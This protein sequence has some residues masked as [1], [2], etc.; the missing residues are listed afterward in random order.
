MKLINA[1]MV[2]LSTI[3]CI[4]CNNSSELRK[5]NKNGFTLEGQISKDSILN[6][7]ILFYDSNNVMVAKISYVNSIKEGPSI[8]YY[9]NGK[10]KDDIE[11]RQG[12]EN[13]YHTV[14]DSAGNIAYRDY[15]F[16][17]VQ[18]G[19]LYFYQNNKCKE[20]YFTS[21]ENETL[22][23]LN[24]DSLSQTNQN[25]DDYFHMRVTNALQDDK[26]KLYLFL[27][28]LNPPSKS[29]NYNICIEDSLDNI[30]NIRKMPSDKIFFQTY[31]DTLSNGNH[32][33]ISLNVYDSATRANHTYIKRIIL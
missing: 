4:G 33:C 26:T 25:G 14:Y 28:L 27:Y 20:Y 21:F 15:Y 18:F 10:E 9:P 5:I 8:N 7:P 3:A 16:H 17:G 24:Y 19:P 11:F 30:N 32:Y 31:L 2:F 1:F 29:F 13:G 23:Y 22:L 12:K 6:G